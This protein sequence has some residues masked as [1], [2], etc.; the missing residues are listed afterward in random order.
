MSSARRRRLD[1]VDGDNEPQATVVALA[2]TAEVAAWPLDVV[3]RPD[4]S[5]V[6]SLARL[7]LAARRVGLTVHVRHASEELCRLLDF[8]GLA[9]LLLE[10]GRE[11][12]CSEQVGVDEMVEPGNSAI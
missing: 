11:A 3:V 9:G 10:A 4:L 12:K 2:G 7:Q 8:S 6:E 1:Y 5:T